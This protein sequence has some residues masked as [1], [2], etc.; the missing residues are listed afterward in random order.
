MAQ[1]RTAMEAGLSCFL[2]HQDHCKVLKVAT[3]TELEA[4]VASLE[5]LLH[6]SRQHAEIITEQRNKL[7]I[8]K[9]DLMAAKVNQQQA[10]TRRMDLVK[11][12][13][14]EQ[15]PKAFIDLIKLAKKQG[16]MTTVADSW[17]ALRTVKQVIY[18]GLDE[19][20][21]SADDGEANNE[22]DTDNEA[23]SEGEGQ[24]VDS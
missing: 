9:L 16:D 11:L 1:K 2:T 21:A 12:A 5:L 22:G 15:F 17:A 20:E 10:F 19:E 24:E 23:D 14:N 18:Y 8:E 4:K 6:A 7:V 13:V 3:K